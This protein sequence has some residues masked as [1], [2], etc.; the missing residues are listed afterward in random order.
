MIG[1]RPICQDN[2]R[3]V[4]ATNA[5]RH[6]RRH[7]RVFKDYH[8]FHVLAFHIGQELRRIGHG[9]L[10]ECEIFGSVLRPFLFHRVFL[11]GRRCLLNVICLNRRDQRD[12]ARAHVIRAHRVRYYHVVRRG[13]GHLQ[14]RFPVRN[15]NCHGLDRPILRRVIYFRARVFRSRVVRSAPRKYVITG[16]SSNRLPIASGRAVNAS[17]KVFYVDVRVFNVLSRV[18]PCV[19]AIYAD[20]SYA[21]G[22]CKDEAH[23]DRVRPRILIQR[24]NVTSHLCAN[25]MV[26]S[27]RARCFLSSVGIH[28]PRFRCTLTS[29]KVN[30]V[31]RHGGPSNFIS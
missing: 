23:Q 10:F 25:P 18:G 26:A 9:N 24:T 19:H 17:T 28:V 14:G 21:V 12:L 11:V 20:L 1:S 13:F 6:A 27:E 2:A 7:L 8:R 5:L 30:D 3:R 31:N 22:V 16:N 29:F 15:S 4:E